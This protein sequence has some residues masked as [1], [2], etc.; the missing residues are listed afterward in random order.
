MKECKWYKVCP[1]AFYFEN[2]KLDRKWVDDYCY[3]DWKS[4]RRYYN[5]ENGIPHPDNMLPNGE[6][7][8]SLQ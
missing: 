7:D 1:M 3:G 4:C 6:I 2:N 8:E 5:E